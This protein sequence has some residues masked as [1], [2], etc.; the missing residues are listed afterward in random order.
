MF[1]SEKKMYVENSWCGGI[2]TNE[3][4]HIYNLVNARQYLMP[5]GIALRQ[6]MAPA[7]YRSLRV[8]LY[9][10]NIR[11]TRVNDI[12]TIFMHLTGSQAAANT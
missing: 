2:Q 7:S 11:Q 5:L 8:A 3:K 9:A 4:G 12:H 1:L 10:I 6:E